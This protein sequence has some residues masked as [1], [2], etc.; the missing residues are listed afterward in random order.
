MGGCIANI[1]LLMLTVV[2]NE[3]FS[4]LL[5]LQ[6]GNGLWL[7]IGDVFGTNNSLKCYHNV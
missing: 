7:C 6:H 1:L 4:H 2:T 5:H 3:T